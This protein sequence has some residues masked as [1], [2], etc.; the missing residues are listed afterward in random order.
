MAIAFDNSNTSNSTSSATLTYS[1]TVGTGANRFLIVGF[2]FN[3]LVL[4]SITGV[5]Y[6]GVAMTASANNPKNPTGD[7]TVAVALFYLANPASG[8]NNVVIT[9]GGTADGISSQAASYTGVNNI[10]QDFS[11][12]GASGTSATLTTTTTIDNS[13]LVGIFRNDAD[14]NGTAGTGTTRRASITGQ[15]AL[16]DSNAAL[17]PAGS[18]SIIST[19]SSAPYSGIGFSMAPATATTNSAFFAFM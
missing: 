10:P 16:Y 12:V 8:A 18:Y 6:N 2:S 3:K 13:W 9:L 11:V 17:T 1:L 7:V 5:T 4:P 19:F 15:S 14:G